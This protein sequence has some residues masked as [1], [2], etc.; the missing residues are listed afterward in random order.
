LD[1]QHS[2][3]KR[4]GG[5]ID[6][7]LE[8]IQLFW[9]KSNRISVEIH[10]IILLGD[11]QPIWMDFYSTGKLPFF[12]DYYVLVEGFQTDDVF[13]LFATPPYQHTSSKTV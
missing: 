12:Y 7:K 5:Q 10:F 9:L 8:E 3:R 4:L 6:Q 2:N 11:V 13:I 1:I